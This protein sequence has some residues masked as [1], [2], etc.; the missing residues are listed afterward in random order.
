MLLSPDPDFRSGIWRERDLHI[1]GAPQGFLSEGFGNL[2]GPGYCVGCVP[3]KMTGEI[4]SYA[5]KAKVLGS[6]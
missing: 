2:G 3:S 1:H 4:S 5:L 6:L